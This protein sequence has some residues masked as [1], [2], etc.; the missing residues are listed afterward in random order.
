MEAPRIKTD[1]YYVHNRGRAFTRYVAAVDGVWLV[2]KDGIIR[3]F[4]TRHAARIAATQVR[5]AAMKSAE[6]ASA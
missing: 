3:K 6:E 2:R 5:D 1:T 4:M